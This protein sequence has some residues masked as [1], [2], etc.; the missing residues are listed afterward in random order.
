MDHVKK[1]TQGRNQKF[2]NTGLSGEREKNL[3]IDWPK[4]AVSDQQIFFKKGVTRGGGQT[5]VLWI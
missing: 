4:T 5:R 2:Y 1:A 3:S